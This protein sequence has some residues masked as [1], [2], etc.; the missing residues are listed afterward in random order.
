M[1]LELH[2]VEAID[3]SRTI[4]AQSRTS[5]VGLRASLEKSD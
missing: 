3:L 2:E 1:K 4:I 5:A